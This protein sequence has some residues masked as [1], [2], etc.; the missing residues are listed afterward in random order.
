VCC[1]IDCAEVCRNLLT[2]FVGTLRE[3]GRNFEHLVP[4]MVEALN[5][6]DVS[7]K[8]GEWYQKKN[9][10]EDT[11]KI[12]FLVFKLSPCCENRILSSFG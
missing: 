12:N 8:F 10:T 1:S 4:Y 9:K 3:E 5:T 11:N 2:R 7:K 6:R